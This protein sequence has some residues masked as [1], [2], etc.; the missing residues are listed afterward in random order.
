MPPGRRYTGKIPRMG[1]LFARL[2]YFKVGMDDAQ[3]RLLALLDLAVNQKILPLGQSVGQITWRPIPDQIN[4]AGVV[5]QHRRQHLAAPARVETVLQQHQ[6]TGKALLLAQRCLV[7][8]LQLAA[9]LKAKRQVI[10][11]V[12][13]GGEPAGFELRRALG[14]DALEGLNRGRESSQAVAR[15]GA[16][17]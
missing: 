2:Q 10:E 9:V 3:A 5:A 4:R 6:L 14:T 7:D 13:D 16:G 12:F 17:L 1:A 11:N 8:F 15:I